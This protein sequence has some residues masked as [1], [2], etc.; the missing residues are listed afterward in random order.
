MAVSERITGRHVTLRPATSADR[1]AVYAWLADS[2]VTAAMFGPPDE[3][4]AAVPSRAEHDA[5]YADLFFDDSRLERGRS[6]LIEV[7][8][9]AV[10]HVSYDRLDELDGVAELDIWMRDRASCGQGWGPDALDAL[11][12]HLGERRGARACLLRPSPLNPRAV[13]A[14][15]RAGFRRLDLSPAEHEARFGPPDEPGC[16]ILWRDLGPGGTP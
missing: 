3:R 1:D 5:D 9:V 14:Y 4:R 8:G 11:A 13:A 12:R 10:G 16:P 6:F 2:D 15:E 7:D